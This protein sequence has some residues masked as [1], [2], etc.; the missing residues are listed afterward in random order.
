MGIAESTLSEWG[1]TFEHNVYKRKFEGI[2]LKTWALNWKYNKI[3]K[4][5]YIS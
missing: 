1:V 2:K 3:V 4:T 5:K